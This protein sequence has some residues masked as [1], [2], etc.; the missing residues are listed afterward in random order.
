MGVGFCEFFREFGQE[1]LGGPGAGFSEGADGASGDV[2]RDVF[3]GGRVAFDGAAVHHAGGHFCHPEAAF[4]AGGAL[5]ATFVGVEEIE[6]VEGFEHVAGV[7]HDD[8]A[9]TADHSACGSESGRVHD[10]IE[11]VDFAIDEGT[12]GSFGFGF[13]FFAHA[14][15]FGRASAGDDGFEGASGAGATTDIEE[16]FPESDRA[17]RKFI[18]AGF[19]HVAAH[20]HHAGAAIARGAHF[21]V[22]VGTEAED[23]FYMADG[24][25]VVD[26]GRSHV[27]AEDGR[28]VGGLD[29][30]IGAFAF[31][32]FEKAGF[33]AADVS[34]CALVDIDV[35]VE[36]GAKNIGAQEAGFAGFADGLCDDAGG[37][38][39]FA[40]DVDVGEFD[41]EGVGGN[42]DS[43]EELVG[44]LVKDVAVFEGARFGFVAIDDEVVGFA[45]IGPEEAPFDSG[46]ESGSAASAE[47]GGFDLVED[48]AG[49]EG[50]SLFELVVSAVGEVGGQRGG[51]SRAGE[52]FKN[53]PAFFG[54]RSGRD[55]GHGRGKVGAGSDGLRNGGGWSLAEIRENARDIGG[56]HLFVEVVVDEANRGGAAGGETLDEFDTKFAVRGGREGAVVGVRGIR[57]NADGFAEFTI[58]FCA[59]GQRAGEG[60][61]DADD[62]FPGSDLTEPG[63]KSDQ[64]EDIDRLEIQ[65]GGDPFDALFADKS[66]LVLPEMDEGQRGA[67]F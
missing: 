20:A 41:A 58:E 56:G 51:V 32:G 54:M 1:A 30:G 66:K 63:I 25:D 5:A 7:V 6:V 61:A 12:V 27:E 18:G 48:V 37:V 53:D 29:A 40:A 49:L 42:G 17:C 35:E 33:L 45:V 19:L 60:A 21:G 8:H 14:Q 10:D 4:A 36:S 26:N 44:I 2:V 55:A 24:F 3:E 57:I 13:D 38:G 22:F 16:Q 62:V 39:E 23:V 28:E 15:D 46:G 52:I 59:A 34:T 64:F 9:A 47:V 43:F 67:A 31:E 50:E 11:N 65:T